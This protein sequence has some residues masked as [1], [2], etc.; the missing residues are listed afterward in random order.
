[1]LGNDFLIY[2]SFWH[3]GS[4]DYWFLTFFMLLL[5]YFYGIINNKK[6]LAHFNVEVPLCFLRQV[7]T[8]VNL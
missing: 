3:I 6:F 5:I 7:P 4:R 8:E 2:F 1:M